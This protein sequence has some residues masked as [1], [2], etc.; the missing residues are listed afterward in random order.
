MEECKRERRGRERMDHQLM[1]LQS[2]ERLKSKFKFYE[3]TLMAFLFFLLFVCSLFSHLKYLK[4]NKCTMFFFHV[5][6]LFWMTPV[7][8]NIVKVLAVLQSYCGNN[9]LLT[10]DFFWLRKMV[11]FALFLLFSICFC[12]LLNVRQAACNHNSSYLN[13]LFDVC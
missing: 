3:W 6:I 4:Y 7:I 1:V 10:I 13:C 12:F 9:Y 2:I 11:F 5:W 8:K